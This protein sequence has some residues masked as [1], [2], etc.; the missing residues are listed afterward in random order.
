MKVTVRC[1]NLKD[2]DKQFEV[3]SNKSIGEKRFAPNIILIPEI[4][5]L[6]IFFIENFNEPT[7]ILKLRFSGSF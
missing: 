6:L 4:R 3:F 1:N 2:M 5:H 7:C